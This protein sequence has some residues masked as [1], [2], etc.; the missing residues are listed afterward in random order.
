MLLIQGQKY[1]VKTLYGTTMLTYKGCAWD[2][3]EE[4]TR[5]VFK[6]E[7][8]GKLYNE[9]IVEIVEY[10]ASKSDR[11]E[12][13]PDRPDTTVEE[14]GDRIESNCELQRANTVSTSIASEKPEFYDITSMS[15][16]NIQELIWAWLK[17]LKEGDSVVTTNC[18]YGLGWE[19][20]GRADS[21]HLTTV[22]RITDK[23]VYLDDETFHRDSGYMVKGVN[24]Y[25]DRML[26]PPWLNP[27]D[28]SAA[29]VS[30]ERIRGDSLLH[31]APIAKLLAALELLQ[32][33][34]QKPNSG[35]TIRL[36]TTT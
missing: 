8:G 34:T 19:N 9:D 28:L 31:N 4:V 16:A 36:A 7:V 18:Y 22:G 12:T 2:K 25:G 6:E 30:L 23:R 24:G 10:K 15:I 33:S 13:A 35:C 1:I 21:T 5:L 14:E 27:K 17:Q 20:I 11:V 3:E 26:L 32:G 29:S